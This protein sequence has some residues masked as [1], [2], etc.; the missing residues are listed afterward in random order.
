MNAGAYGGEMKD[1]I[2]Y[3]DV[4]TEEGEFLRLSREEL[5]LGYRTSVIQKKNYFVLGAAL[6]LK[7]RRSGSNPFRDGGS[8]GKNASRNS[9][10]NTPARE[11][12]LSGRGLFCRKL[13]MDAGLRG[14]FCRRRGSV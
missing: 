14:F 5:E 7:K 1:V 12:P 13:I 3:S 11:A 8:E 9:R 6:E 4:V 10:W 2:R